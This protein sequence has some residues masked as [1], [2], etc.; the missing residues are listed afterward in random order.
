MQKIR[1]SRDYVKVIFGDDN[2]GYTFSYNENCSFTYMLVDVMKTWFEENINGSWSL[3][4]DL[5]FD[6]PYEY[7]LVVEEVFCVV[8]ELDE[9]AI[10]FKLTWS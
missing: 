5:M 1:I 6:R 9:D 3:I 8:F 7:V 2:I 10:L 4:Y